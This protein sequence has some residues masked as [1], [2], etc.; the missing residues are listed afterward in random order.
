MKRIL[1][2]ISFIAFTAFTSTYFDFKES[3]EIV[4]KEDSEVS[5]SGTSNINSFN[6]CYNISKLESP[7]PVYFEFREKN[8]YFQSTV[9]ELES[10]CFD[11]GH[12]AINKDF[13][14][15]L[16][17]QVYP[18]IKLK[19]LAIER[20]SEQ[21]NTFNAKVEIYIA[22]VVNCFVFPVK[23]SKEEDMRFIGDISLDLRDYKLEAPKKMMGLITVNPNVNVNFNLH[24]KEI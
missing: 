24:L 11:C 18:K 23:V 16:K 12:N 1:L 14:K 2:F 17:T 10:D 7:V 20:N 13:N 6:C 15:L 21:N 4:V 8:M 22:D 3:L 9:L 5:I 19:L